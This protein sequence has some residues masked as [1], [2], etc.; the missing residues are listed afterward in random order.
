MAKHLLKTLILG[1][2]LILSAQ[3]YAQ[4]DLII[5]Q[6]GEE[7]RCKIL[8]ETPTRFIYAYLGPK[9]KVLRNEIFKNLVTSFKYN[10]YDNDI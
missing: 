8:D 9:K 1:L 7:I 4:R 6:A 2:F 10:H 5:T 3:A